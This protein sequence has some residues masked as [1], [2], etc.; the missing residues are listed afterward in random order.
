MA[1]IGCIDVR[2][3]SFNAC[4]V[5]QILYIVKSL[6]GNIF[7]ETPIYQR[8]ATSGLV[9]HAAICTWFGHLQL[10]DQDFLISSQSNKFVR[11]LYEDKTM[12]I[13]PFF[14]KRLPTSAQYLYYIYALSKIY[15]I[16][17]KSIEKS[18]NPKDVKN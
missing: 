7:C 5:S 1:N 17:I 2:Y 9:A 10:I 3:I 8:W 18:E 4:R 6:D 16:A 15:R 13:R 14:L 12:R 11:S